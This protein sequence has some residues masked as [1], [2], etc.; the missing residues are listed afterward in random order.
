MA[1]K[2]PKEQPGLKLGGRDAA[3]FVA[4]TPAIE[5]LLNRPD[6]VVGQSIVRS[7]LRIER[8]AKRRCPVDTGR[9]RASITNRLGRDTEGLYGD[10]GTN[11]DYAPHV[12]VRKPFLRPALAEES[13]RQA[14]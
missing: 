5:E 8:A 4:N 6:G 11:V 13:G 12:E 7:L 9:L 2:Q 3:R 1:G 10:V 14:R